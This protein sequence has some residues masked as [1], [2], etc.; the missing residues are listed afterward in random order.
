MRVHN[1]LFAIGKNIIKSP[2]MN[3]SPYKDCGA[4]TPYT[5]QCTLYGVHCTVA[6]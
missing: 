1:A 5:V 4:C 2:S 6:L 3:E